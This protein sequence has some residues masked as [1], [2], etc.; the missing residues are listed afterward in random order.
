MTELATYSLWGEEFSIPSSTE[1]AKKILKKIKAPKE[2]TVEKQITSKKTPLDEKL[3]LIEREVLKKLGKRRGTITV[4]KSREQLN[5][6]INS[7]IAN[8]IIAIDTETNKSLDP[9]TCVLM[10]PCIY[11]RGQKAAYIPLH[12]RDFQTGR[13]YEWQLKEEDIKEEF[14]RLLDAGVK[15][16][17]HNYKFDFK[18]IGCTCDL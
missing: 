7:A 6:Y 11:T 3:R 16:I 17:W 15:T 14:Q 5:S 8:G 1:Q 12:H 2:V 4:I 9:L 18:V 13:E 10:G